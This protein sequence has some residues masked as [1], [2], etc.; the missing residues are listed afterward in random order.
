MKHIT[1]IMLALLL[2]DGYSGKEN[3]AFRQFYFKNVS[4]IEEYGKM[5]TSDRFEMDYEIIELF[6]KTKD[7]LEI[8]TG[9]KYHFAVIEVPIYES[10]FNL[11]KDISYLKKWYSKYGEK[12]TI[13]K[14]DKIVENWYEN[15]GVFLPAINQDSVI[16]QW[17]VLYYGT[18]TGN[19]RSGVQ[20]RSLE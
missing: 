17:D 14:A 16:H 8:L 13:E 19:G 12:M 3:D 11:W 9:I 1:T 5:C 10:K 6:G 7:Y 2:F 15:H 20:K 4:I 18:S